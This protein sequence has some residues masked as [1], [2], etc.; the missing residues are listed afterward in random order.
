LG[1][2][3]DDRFEFVAHTADIAV[4]LCATTLDGLF[5][6][7]TAAFT[8]A[9]TD[10]AGVRA[11]DTERVTL[12][13]GELDLLLVDLLHELLYLFDTRQFLVSES[14][15]RVEPHAG[16]WRVAA[17]LRGEPRAAGRHAVKVLIK[18]ATYHG[19]AIERTARGY[20]ATIVFDI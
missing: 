10:R 16:G 6:L 20:E 15:A 2:P 7:A 17:E 4:R 13:A 12:E 9:L 14:R 11:R 18:A 19:L 1:A 3:E 5:E 8:E